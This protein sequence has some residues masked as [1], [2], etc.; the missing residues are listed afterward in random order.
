MPSRKTVKTASNGR[1]GKGRFL[2]GNQ[3]ATGNPFAKRTAELR[4][5]LLDA[6]SPADLKRMVAKMICL[7]KDGDVQ[8]FKVL[9]S[10]TVGK[11]SNAVDPD[12]LAAHAFKLLKELPTDDELAMANLF[13]RNTLTVLNG[14]E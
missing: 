13:R 4:T 7:A 9:M 8:A 11:P 10:Y 6:V 5:T 1:D 2:P 3:V 12:T 14:H